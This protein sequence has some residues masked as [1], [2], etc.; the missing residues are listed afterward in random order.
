MDR[1]ARD[2]R[3]EPGARGEGRAGACDGCGAESRELEELDGRRLCLWCLLRVA[4]DGH[5]A[6]VTLPDGVPEEAW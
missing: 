2:R 4:P 3:R 5:V 1:L 6:W